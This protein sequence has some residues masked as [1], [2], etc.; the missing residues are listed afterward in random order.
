MTTAADIVSWTEQKA[1]HALFQD[2]GVLYGD[3][4]TGLKKVTVCWS[5]TP[6]AIRFTAGRGGNFIIHHEV[7]T[8]TPPP[9]FFNTAPDPK[10]LAW[11]FNRQRIKL[12]SENDIGCLRIHGTM[13]E[14]CIFEVF[15]KKIGLAP[16]FIQE[17]GNPFRKLY[18]LEEPLRIGDLIE[19]LK[20]CFGLP[21]VRHTVTD[22]ERSIRTVAL[23]WGGMALSLNVQ[24]LQGLVELGKIDVMI[25]GE[26]DNYAARFC[27]E[28]GIDVIELG[29]EIT[30]DP[31]IE[32][33]S[34]M[35]LQQFCDVDFTFL[36]TPPVFRMHG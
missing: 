29:H 21:G 3:K 35:L 22:M 25:A 16:E 36:L 24:Y 10:H 31:G 18:R 19:K 23:P 27:R 9:F 11:E 17:P 32:D 6:E 13:D 4:N 5:P 8:M 15:R 30:E 7:L 2:E 14:I 34:A 20:T 12:L 28:Q 33:F 26:S 1:G